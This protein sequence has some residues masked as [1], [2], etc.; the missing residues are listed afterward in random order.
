MLSFFSHMCSSEKIV[1]TPAGRNWNTTGWYVFRGI[2]CM[3]F[4]RLFILI[5]TFTTD[6][7]Y[8]TIM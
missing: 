2:C 3:V 7:Y 8:E 6:S 5:K 1:K 4:P